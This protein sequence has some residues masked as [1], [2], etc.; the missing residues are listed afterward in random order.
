MDEKA[1]NRYK[2]QKL[3]TESEKYASFLH[4]IY[5]YRQCVGGRPHFNRAAEMALGYV[6]FTTIFPEKMDDN[7]DITCSLPF[8]HPII[9]QICAQAG[10]SHELVE[11]FGGVYNKLYFKNRIIQQ[12]RKNEPI[13]F[14]G[15]PYGRR[16]H[17]LIGYKES[18]DSIQYLSDQGIVESADWYDFMDEFVLMNDDLPD[19]RLNIGIRSIIRQALI[20]K[21]RKIPGFYM[22]EDAYK[23]W[24]SLNADSDRCLNRLLIKRMFFARRNVYQLLMQFLI[25]CPDAFSRLSPALN[26]IKRLLLLES[27]GN[28]FLK[29]RVQQ[30]I[31]IDC[32]LMEML[33]HEF[34]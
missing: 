33:I 34:I 12:L 25:Q 11:K 8:Y 4:C 28:L 27:E 18:E 20:N 1:V 22:D 19:Q 9:G 10:Y 21:T 15:S 30:M 17:L 31:D 6:S 7:L 24:M 13:I 3:S 2:T 23:I 32:Q 29:Q 14:H 5:Q 26:A 16:W